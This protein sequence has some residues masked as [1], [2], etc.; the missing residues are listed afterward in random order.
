MKQLS[1]FILAAMLCVS[2]VFAQKDSLD[3]KQQLQTLKLVDSVEKVLNW[4]TGEVTIGDGIAKLNVIPGFKFLNAA[5]SQYVLHDLWGN[6]PRTDVLGMLFPDNGGPFNDSSYAFIISYEET[7]FIKDGDAD[8]INY[9]EMLTEM[10]KSEPDE[11]KERAKQGYEPIHILSWAQSPFYDSKRKV[12][13]WAKE[14]EFGTSA[15]HTLNYDVRV[16][17]RKGILSLN[18]VATMQELPLVKAN[19]DKVLSIPTFTDGNKYSDFN[20]NTDKVAAYGIGAV[21]AG[22]ILAK[23]GVLAIIGKFLVAA[24]KFIMIGIVAAIAGIKKFF[25]RKKDSSEAS[26]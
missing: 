19:I 2:S 21:V 24:W 16:L 20:S 13:H 7:G 9:S 3:I 26:V 11:N 4:K 5:Q 25:G 22:G 15:D 14:I 18:A 1:V 17:G 8:K 6:P 12:L 23:T 10:Q